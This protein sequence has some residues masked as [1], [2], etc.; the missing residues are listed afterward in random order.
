MLPVVVARRAGPGGR[1]CAMVPVRCAE[2]VYIF[3][4]GLQQQ[5]MR[6]HMARVTPSWVEVVVTL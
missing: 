3:L 1:L 2:H 6:V 5:G 4:C